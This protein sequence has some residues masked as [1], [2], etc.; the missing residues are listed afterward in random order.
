[1]A[2]VPALTIQAIWGNVFDPMNQTPDLVPQT[3]LVPAQLLQIVAQALV[4]PLL[5]VAMTAFFIDTQVR[6][7]GLDLALALEQPK[8]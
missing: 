8:A 5:G 4:A 3:L 6:R 2:G 7:E 1:M